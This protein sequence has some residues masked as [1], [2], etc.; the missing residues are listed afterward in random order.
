MDKVIDNLWIGPKEVALDETVL[1]C[2]GINYII[3]LGCVVPAFNEIEY[4]RFSELLDTPEFNILDILD[5]TNDFISKSLNKNSG[6]V[7]VHC[8]YGQVKMFKL[9]F[10]KTQSCF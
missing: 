6:G 10:F 5:V 9:L 4:L 1:K 8:V 3:S 7:L 2:N